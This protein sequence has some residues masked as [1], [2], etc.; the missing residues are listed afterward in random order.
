MMSTD[1]RTPLPV[2]KLQVGEVRAQLIGS[3]PTAWARIAYCAEDGNTVGDTTFT[4]WSKESWELL[5][6]L[7]DQVEKDLASWMES[8]SGWSSPTEDEGESFEEFSSDGVDF[9]G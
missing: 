3:T 1:L 2:T 7:C 9:V 6:A 8:R 5:I 4:A